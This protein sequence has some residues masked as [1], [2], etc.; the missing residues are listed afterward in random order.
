MFCIGSIFATCLFQSSNTKALLI[1]VILMNALTLVLFTQFTSYWSLAT[2][3]MLTGFFQVFICIYYP[4]WADRF[5][6]S[7]QQKATFMSILLLSSTTGVMIGYICSSMIVQHSSWKNIFYYE[8]ICAI[9]FVLIIILSP[10]KYLDLQY[11]LEL[12]Q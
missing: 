8:A 12:K 9:P 2:T 10:I 6:S 11:A 5:G 3:R 1:T 4:V 7:H